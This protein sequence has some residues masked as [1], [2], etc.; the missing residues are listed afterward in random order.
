M[1]SGACIKRYSPLENK[2]SNS[3]LLGTNSYP[4]SCEAVLNILNHYLS[5]I[6]TQRHHQS[7]QEGVTFIQKNGKGPGKKPREN[8][9]GRS[10]CFHYG[11]E[12]YQA[13][14]CPKMLKSRKTS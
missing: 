2:L 14:Q 9:A 10:D 11:E 8:K 7:G 6:S 13:H 5:E 12:G 1:L 3:M 4:K